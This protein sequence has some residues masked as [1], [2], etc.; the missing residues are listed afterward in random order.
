MRRFDGVDS[1]AVEILNN[2]VGMIDKYKQ[3]DLELEGILYLGR[4]EMRAI[5]TIGP[6]DI[7]IDR[8][9]ETGEL[10]LYGFPIVPVAR[11]TYAA[12]APS[13]IWRR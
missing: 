2:L 11:N 9:I 10:R 5:Y 8:Y 4:K 3:E 1:I 7:S 12:L 13:K 6:G